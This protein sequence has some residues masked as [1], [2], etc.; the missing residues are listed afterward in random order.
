MNKI[1]KILMDRDGDTR[2]EAEQLLKDA[3]TELNNDDCMNPE[4]I[5]QDWFGLEPDYI[6]D[7]IEE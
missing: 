3:R 4:E 5:L 6:F 7:L 2:E 1:V